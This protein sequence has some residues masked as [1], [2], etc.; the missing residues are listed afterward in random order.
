LSGSKLGLKGQMSACPRAH[1]CVCYSSGTPVCVESSS[2]PV[3]PVSYIIG[4]SH[5]SFA[6]SQALILAQEL[7]QA[8]V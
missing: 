4:E 6:P 8:C 3:Y 1:L 5:T 2:M 7:L